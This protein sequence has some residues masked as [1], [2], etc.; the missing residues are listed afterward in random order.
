MTSGSG[1][2]PGRSSLSA[3][4]FQRGRRLHAEH[5]QGG[6][7]PEPAPVEHAFEVRVR[8]GDARVEVPFQQLVEQ[9]RTGVVVAEDAEVC[10]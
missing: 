6:V 5:G 9:V 1:P 4:T 3:A 8:R 2:S 10:A 7:L